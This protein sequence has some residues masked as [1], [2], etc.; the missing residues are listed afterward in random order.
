MAEKHSVEW[1]SRWK[2]EY[3][4]WICGFANA[5]GGSLY[6]GLDDEG[7][8]VGLSDSGKLLEDLPNKIRD[9]MGIIV[10]VNL[11]KE[12]NLEYIEIE[13]PPYPIAISC[14]GSYYYRSGSTNQKLIGPELESF[15]LRRRGITWD[16]ASLPYFTMDDVDDD[17]IKRFKARAAKKGRIDE[18]VLDES[19]E[20]LMEKLHLKNAGFLTNAAMLLF[21]SDPEKWLLGAFT[22]I[23][24]FESDADLLYQDEIHGSILDQVD[25]IVELVY[26]KYMKAKI[27]YEGIQRIERYFVPEEALREALLNA[28]IHKDYAS[29]IPIQISVYE[30]RLYIAN[31]GQLPES[32][33]VE[34]L[35]SKHASQPFNPHIAHVFYLAGFIESWG[36]GIEKIFDACRKDGVPQPEYTIHTGDIMIKFTAPEGRIIKKGTEKGPKKGLEKGPENVS[37]KKAKRY[38]DIMRLISNNASISIPGIAKELDIGI[39]A[40]KTDIKELQNYGVIERIGSARGGYW[41]IIKE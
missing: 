1:K 27:S 30:D 26:L 29:G 22:K 3:L 10:N 19:K 25:K 24:Y 31:C 11:H 37:E 18:S 21:S 14:K 32:W 17:V 41:K 16:H 36:R 20:N 40:V 12:G 39:K 9:A 5:Q 28:I 15:I 4:A 23:G 38:E 34:N 13:V 35:M 8:P 7:R 33:T 2:D 6:I